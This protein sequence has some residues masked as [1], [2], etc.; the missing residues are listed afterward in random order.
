MI[1]VLNIISD[2]NIGG[3]GRVLLN[4]LRCR[5]PDRFDV[6]VA[7]PRGSALAP[8]VRE[9][10]VEVR[11]MDVEPDKSMSLRSLSQLRAVIHEI[12]PDIVHTHGFLAARMAAR[13]CGC[14]VIFTR[15]S[16]FP[17]K[18]W[19]K[20][21][22][23]RWA[24]RL[25]N[26]RYADRIIAV[27]PAAAENLTDSGVP[28]DLIEIVMNGV[29]KVERPAPD[30]LEALRRSLGLSQGDFVL[31]I[32]ARLEEYKG[33]EDILEALRLVTEKRPE[34][35]LLIAGTGPWEG[36]VRRRIG[37][38][39]L[40]KNALMLGFVPDVSGVL[41]LL[42]V[43]LNASW[44]TEATSMALLEGFSM[45]VPAV[46]SDYGGNP[47]TVE[48]GTDGLLFRTRDTRDLAG[49]ILRLMDDRAELQRLSRG[50]E[51]AWSRRFTAQ[52][53][54]ENIERIYTTVWEDRHGR[55]K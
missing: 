25:I 4:Y 55:E 20:K 16:A 24:N 13:R 34:A 28:E 19:M 6:S 45:G 3:A 31:G 50:A 51:L 32:L 33:H 43:Q 18:P 14:G 21:G 23:G 11:E 47:W 27:S 8:A 37:E 42:D 54:A 10:G 7:L 2:T 5:D 15:H 39:G 48:D 44:G 46:A 1:K 49:K 40:E 36:A 53:M 52:V 38:L 26:V 22:P 35:K 29:E 17:V 30:I 12:G 41:G 9:L